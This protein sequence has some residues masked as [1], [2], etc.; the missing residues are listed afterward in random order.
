MQRILLCLMVL[1]MG[2]AVGQP[3]P[4]EKQSPYATSPPPIQVVMAD[5]GQPGWPGTCGYTCNADGFWTNTCTGWVADCATSQ[6]H[7]DKL[8]P[9]CQDAGP[10]CGWQCDAEGVWYDSCSG[11]AGTCAETVAH[12]GG[13][14][15]A[16]CNNTCQVQTDPALAAPADYHCLSADGGAGTLFTWEQAAG[17]PVSSCDVAPCPHGAVCQIPTSP[18]E[19]L[20]TGTCF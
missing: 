18:G 4:G 8:P 12:C 17:D 19:V 1:V 20:L 5:A 10:T 7:C 15:P 14:V 2:C 6:Q 3:A 9:A 16:Y 13:A 11:V